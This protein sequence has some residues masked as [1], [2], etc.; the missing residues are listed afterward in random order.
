QDACWFALAK[1]ASMGLRAAAPALT[2]SVLVIGCG[3]VGQMLVRWLHATG[4]TRIVAGDPVAL[5]LRL[6]RDGGATERLAVEAEDAP[7]ALRERGV[8]PKVVVDCTGQPEVLAH[9]LACAADGGRVVLVGDNG[10]P[11]R[12]QLTG[13][14][15]FR[16]LTI[17]GVHDSLETPEWN[18]AS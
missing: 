7:A 13:D 17:H 14:L 9:A 11:G 1:I 4:I 10:N 2:D 8:S 15:L 18:S 12:Q 16:G 3:P 5:R 6:A